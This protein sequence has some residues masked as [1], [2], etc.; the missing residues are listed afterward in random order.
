MTVIKMV[1]NIG[2]GRV[3][4]EVSVFNEGLKRQLSEEEACKGKRQR[5]VPVCGCSRGA[6]AG[7]H[8]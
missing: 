6:S 3:K 4:A 7:L 8:V 2:R 1:K 5:A